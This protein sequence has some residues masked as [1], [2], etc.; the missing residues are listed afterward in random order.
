MCLQLL[1][2]VSSPLASLPD[3]DKEK[4]K[5]KEKDAAEASKSEGDAMQTDESKPPAVKAEEE[6]KEEPD[7]IEIPANIRDGN[8][9]AAK[10]HF[11]RI[12]R[13][14]VGV[15]RLRRLCAVLREDVCKDASFTRV[16]SIMASLSKVKENRSLL[17]AE[18]ST[19]ALAL[20]SDA[21]NDLTDL[22]KQVRECLRRSEAKILPYL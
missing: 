7:I 11:Q 2:S 1:E 13:P 8:G 9:K 20:G 12:P 10:Y 5:E 4:E 17:L 14:V 16:M 22:N 21:L 6:K 18:L 19:V 15:E 3:I